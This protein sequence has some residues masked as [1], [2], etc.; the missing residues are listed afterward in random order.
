MDFGGLVTRVHGNDDQLETDYASN[1]LYDRFGQRLSMTNG[2]RPST[3]T[4]T[5]RTTAASS[6]CRP[7][8]PWATPSTI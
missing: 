5:E 8:C 6:T 2:N 7:R 1:I 4:P 3:P